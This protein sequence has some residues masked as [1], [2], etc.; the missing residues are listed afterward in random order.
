MAVELNEKQQIKELDV[1]RGPVKS[2]DDAKQELEE[3][4]AF[5]KSQMKEGEDYGIIPGIKT[6]KPSLWQPGAEKLVDFHGLS[7]ELV[8]NKEATVRDWNKPFFNFDY[9]CVLTHRRSGRRIEAVGSCNSMEEKY[10]YRWVFASELPENTDKRKLKRKTIVKNRRRYV[11]FRVQNKEIASLVN[12]IQKMAR[13]RSLVGATL[14]A[15]RASFYFTQDL[16]DMEQP[17][18]VESE[19]VEE[20]PIEKVEPQKRTTKTKEPVTELTLDR[21]EIEEVKSEILSDEQLLRIRELVEGSGGKY[22]ERMYKHLTPEGA[23]KVIKSL[24]D[25]LRKEESESP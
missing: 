24:E 25:K 20:N 14:T 12:T 11:L 1:F 17:V 21:I 9:K 13:K 15:T 19:V 18:D 5:I 22:K 8:E 7:V 6:K 23:D 2:L 10:R 4:R 3:L 16:E